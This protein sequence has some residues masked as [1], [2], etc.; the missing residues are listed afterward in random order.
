MLDLL[1]LKTFCTLGS[2]S[3]LVFIGLSSLKR[4]YWILISSLCIH[5]LLCVGR[6]LCLF[7]EQNNFLHLAVATLFMVQAI[8]TF[9]FGRAPFNSENK[10]A[11]ALTKLSILSVIVINLFALFYSMMVAPG[12]RDG[13]GACSSTFCFSQDVA[14]HSAICAIMFV[15]LYQ[16]HSGLIDTGAFNLCGCASTSAGTGAS[17]STGASVAYNVGAQTRAQSTAQKTD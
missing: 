17:T 11:Y 3:T 6:Q 16:Y 1:F 10:S 9:P 2:R 12:I 4:N 14:I 15:R 8:L 5:A 7:S 13:E